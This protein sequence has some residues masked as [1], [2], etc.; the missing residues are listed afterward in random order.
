MMPFTHSFSPSVF[1]IAWGKLRQERGKRAQRHG[2]DA[3]ELQHRLL[4]ED[5]RVELSGSSPPFSRHHSIAASGKAASFL[6]RE[7]RSSCT[8]ATGT[9]STSSAAAESW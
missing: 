8:A 3:L 6:R 5:H 9:P 2:Q 7:S 1:F 4:V